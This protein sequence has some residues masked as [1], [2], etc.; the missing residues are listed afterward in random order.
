[1]G[2]HVSIDL[3]DDLIAYLRSRPELPENGSYPDRIMR[4]LIEKL[5][6]APLEVTVT[7]PDW[8]VGSLTSWLALDEERERAEGSTRVSDVVALLVYDTIVGKVGGE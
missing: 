2:E 6:P 7:M 4:L 1:M 8:L 5:P 3:D